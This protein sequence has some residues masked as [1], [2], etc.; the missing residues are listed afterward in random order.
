MPPSTAN[1]QRWGT[2]GVCRDWSNTGKCDKRDSCPYSHPQRT[3]KGTQKQ[4][5][6]AAPTTEASITLPQATVAV[7]DAPTIATVGVTSRAGDSSGTAA[8]GGTPVPVVEVTP[9][10]QGQRKSVTWD[11]VQT[12]E[13][14]CPGWKLWRKAGEVDQR[15]LGEA[16]FPGTHPSKHQMNGRHLS[17]LCARLCAYSLHADVVGET[18]T[19]PIFFLPGVLGDQWC[20]LRFQAAMEVV[21]A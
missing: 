20:G 15:R 2:L 10:A 13:F 6:L 9:R 3:A 14:P 18:S 21:G 19:V 5:L 1:S 11:K 17:S 8:T 7:G 4:D 12:Y 16:D